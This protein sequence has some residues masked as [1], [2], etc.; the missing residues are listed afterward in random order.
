[1]VQLVVIGAGIV[2]LAVAHYFRR[3]HGC[4]TLVV[5]RETRIGQGISS[6]N[7][8]VIHAGLYYPAGSHKARLCVEGRERLYRYLHEHDLPHRKC[9]KYVVA[10]RTEED[11]LQRLLQQGLTNGV[12]DLEPVNARDLQRVY[13]QLAPCPAIYSPSTGILS[14]DTVMHQLAGE[15]QAAGGDLALQTTFVGLEHE[16]GGGYQ[17]NMADASGDRLT[18]LAERVVNAA[19][20]DALNVAQLAGFDYFQRGYTLRYCKGTYFHVP[21]AR[22]I[23]RHLLYPL[24]LP[25]YLGIHTCL[26]MQDEVRL[27]PDARYLED[28]VLDY[29]VDPALEDEFRGSVRTFW[30]EIDRYTL[31]ADWAGIRPHLYMDDYY[32]DDFLIAEES[33]AGYPG[34]I[35]LLGIDSPGLTAALAFGPYLE[36]M[37]PA[38]TRQ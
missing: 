27:G 24:P 28:P 15:F 32:H 7:S 4:Q 36:T 29:S 33:N 13:P 20:L 1:M 26:D 5:E 22:G 18:L 2:G 35:N 34:W 17:L 16:P 25:N 23:F 12:R 8:E 19:G 9:G 10:S 14:V 6:R 31:Q 21:E 3:E 38:I 37:F 11:Q 30:P